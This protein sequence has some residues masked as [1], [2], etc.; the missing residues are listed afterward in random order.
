MKIL[1]LI[2]G[3][4][5]N[6]G[7]GRNAR[8][9]VAALQA[10]GHKVLVLEYKNNFL[11]FVRKARREAKQSDIVQA[12]DI[13][14]VGFA[15]Y[16]AT[17][18][19]R[20]KF[21]IIAQAAYAVAP[22]HNRKTALF[23]QIVYKSADAVVAGSAFVAREIQKK[24]RNIKVEVIDPGIDM[25]QF[26][27]V[28]RVNTTNKPQF[29]ISVGAVK[30]R[31]GQDISLRAFALLKK[32][33]PDLRYIIVGSQTNEPKYF[34]NL[35]ALARE[36]GV[37]KDVDF[38]TG[39]SDNHLKDLYSR[40]SLFILTSV[41]IGFHF[42]GFGMVFLEAA[43]YGV[44]SVGTLG[45]GIEGAVDDGKT[46][47]LV[48]QKDP[49]AAAKAALE[50]LTDPDRAKNMGENATKFAAMHG[51]GHLTGCYERLYCDMLVKI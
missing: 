47:I 22:L 37:E 39:V 23:S 42:E 31:K 24:V 21:I 40:A 36:L 1:L 19:I 11:N 3:A 15:G 16:F 48:P 20:V 6:D 38:L 33:I 49:V 2:N 45:N 10:G 7:A 8:T 13:N 18:F 34:Y 4:G 51:I 17:R 44:P 5:I 35:V 26:T 9:M 12:V 27:G 41:N 32:D 30:A 28:T 14:P 25:S 46:G 50:I 29:M 43:A